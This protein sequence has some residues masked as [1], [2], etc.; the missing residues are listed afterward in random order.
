MSQMSLRALGKTVTKLNLRRTSCLG[1]VILALGV[2][3]SGRIFA[4]GTI[5]VVERVTSSDDGEL[6]RI[7]DGEFTVLRSDLQDPLD[8][9]LLADGTLLVS[10][11]VSADSRTGFM[12]TI[13]P[14][15]GDVLHSFYPGFSPSSIFTDVDST[16]YVTSVDGLLF[17]SETSRRGRLWYP[18]ST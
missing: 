15:T 4:Q 3:L 8:I 7:T 6:T 10:E 9:E 11:L 1:L 16:L 17:R 14:Q 2:L 18:A 13:D 5:Y 12:T